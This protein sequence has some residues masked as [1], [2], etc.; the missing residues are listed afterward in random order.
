MS[1][2]T[3]KETE[4]NPQSRRNF[5]VSAGAVSASAIVPAGLAACG[6]GDDDEAVGTLTVDEQLALTATQAVDAIK[7]GRMSAVAYTQTLLSRAVRLQDLNS[8]ISLNWDKALAAATE[9][10]RKRRSG[11]TLPALAGLPIVVKDNI[12]TVDLPTTGAT[13]AL[14]NVR[15][16]SNQPTLQR[17]IDAGAIVL[18]KANLH[19][20]AFGTTNTNLTPFAGVC[21]NPYDKRRVPGGS[22]GGTGTAVAARIATAG[23]GSDTGGSVRIPAAL[24]GIAGLR[25][26]VGNG[27][28]QRR[29]SGSGV[30]PISH[31]RDT[32]GPM[33]RTVADV[34]LLDSVM[35][36]NALPAAVSLSGLRIGVPASFWAGVDN[37]V[38]SVVTAARTRLQAAGVTFVNV[39]MPGIWALDDQVS[40]TVVLHEAGSDIPAYLAATGVTGVTLADIAAGV[41]SPDV[42]GPIAAVL[43]DPTAGAYDNALNVLRPQMQ[44]TYASYFADNQLDAMFF[45]T[46]SIQAPLID[47]ING[48]GTVSINGGP[49][50]D[51]FANMIRNSDPGSNT[52]VP[53]LTLPAG[54][55]AAGMPV[56]LSLDGPMGGDSRLL[57]IGIAM[58]AV[59]GLLPAPNV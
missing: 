8:M 28:A 29:Y 17:L 14:R 36:G 20:L 6:G 40:F 42:K 33:A 43:A 27:G 44:T 54:R 46:T 3:R 23:L 58:E 9:I 55:T 22:S 11:E 41:S 51:T 12:N 10:D 15:P 7:T 52:G 4:V 25:P 50:V 32:I 38:V 37:E 19:E 47:V 56:G 45:P 26:T 53:G 16:T 49:P 18:G 1:P 13:S 30:L 2:T 57:A 31:T 24:C 35:S 21:Q 59:L 34:A 39:D 5:L 48:S